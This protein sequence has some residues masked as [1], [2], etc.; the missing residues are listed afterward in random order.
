VKAAIN[1]GAIKGT[2]RGDDVEMAGGT[3][4]A[5]YLAKEGGKSLF[6]EESGEKWQR[7]KVVPLK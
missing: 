7:A 4:L 5:D 6:P 2:I 1:K 3:A